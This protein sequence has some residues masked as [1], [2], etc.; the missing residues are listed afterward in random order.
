MGMPIRGKAKLTSNVASQHLAKP[1]YNL[2]A[3]R[4]QSF[5]LTHQMTFFF[6]KTLLKLFPK[7]TKVPTTEYVVK[8]IVFCFWGFMSKSSAMLASIGKTNNYKLHVKQIW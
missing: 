2:V 5:I 1:L 8:V 7:A 3:H 4:N 6:L